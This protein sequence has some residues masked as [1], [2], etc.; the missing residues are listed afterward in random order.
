MFRD[1]GIFSEYRFYLPGRKF[2]ALNYLF[3]VGRSKVN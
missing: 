2:F 3:A 1:L